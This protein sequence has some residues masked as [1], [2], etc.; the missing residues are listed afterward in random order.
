MYG[1]A[2]NRPEP[3]FRRYRPL[4]VQDFI[5]MPKQKFLLFL[6]VLPLVARAQTLNPSSPP[7]AP[8][9]CE[10]QTSDTPWGKVLDPKLWNHLHFILFSSQDGLRVLSEWNEWGFFARTFTLTDSN[11]KQYTVTSRDHHNWDGNY[12]GTVTINSGEVLVS[13]VYLC[14]GSWKVSPKLPFE[15][16]H[17]PVTGHYTLKL[18][19]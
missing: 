11:S 6:L 4:R 19:Q 8:L 9:R 2:T 12:P 5:I 17:W 15:E 14:D 16:I 18:G 10:L 7:P 3:R 1:L 13:D